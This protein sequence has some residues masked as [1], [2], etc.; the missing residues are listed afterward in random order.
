M[1]EALIIETGRQLI[2]K[3]VETGYEKAYDN[4]GN[5]FRTV[6]LTAC[7]GDFIH[8]AG[9]ELSDSDPLLDEV[10]IKSFY[11]DEQDRI[12]DLLKEVEDTGRLPE[13]M[14][15]KANHVYNT[16]LIDGRLYECSD[17]F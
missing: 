4:H 16:A 15:K 14:R 2:A 1:N 3:L 7:I 5:G 11:R 6:L 12:L 8:A 10:S 13:E 17:W 9:L